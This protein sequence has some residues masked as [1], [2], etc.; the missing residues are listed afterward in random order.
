ME[1]TSDTTQQAPGA[2]SVARAVGLV[3]PA[4]APAR[5]LRDPRAVTRTARRGPRT[6]LSPAARQ[7][8]AWIVAIYL[9]ARIVLLIAAFIQSRLG[10]APFQNELANWDGFWYREL[11]N[12]GYPSHVVDGQT[13]LGF[14]PLFPLMIWPL[15]HV[16]GL[17]FHED[18][19]WLATYAGAIISGVGGLIAT[20]FV[21]RLTDGWWGRDAARRAT[22]LFVLFPGA[23]VFTMV[24]TEGVLLAL[25]TGC[26]YALERRRWLLAGILAG[27]AT[28]VQPVGLALAPVCLLSALLELRRQGWSIREAR[29]AF[30][31]PLLS[32]S[33]AGAFM[34]FLWAWTGSPFANYIAQH[35]G[36]QESTSVFALVHTVNKLAAEVSFTHFNEPTINLNYV[37]GLI[38]AAAL[39]L[40]LVLL[41][42]SRR[43]VSP[44]AIAWSLAIAFLGLTS[45]MVP[46][47]PRMLITAFPALLTL[48][49]YLHGR[50]F[51]VFAW[52]N[53]V[54]LVGLSLF[55]FFGLTLRP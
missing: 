1:T 30:I 18:L 11:A 4:T 49:R 26:I 34:A 12:K 43:Q 19:Q 39:L 16:L 42:C 48:A 9:G 5:R 15:E 37:S 24:Y 32:V 23:V 3:E 47:N 54:A 21:H 33:G 10:H 41:A 45:S 13:T 44:E 27:F 20:I 29:R 25:V 28:A 31:A 53:G 6:R 51:T 36:W 14:F 52:L 17:F 8:V 35:R 38:G 46:P 55:T 40:M 2:R 50:W 7:E 22:V